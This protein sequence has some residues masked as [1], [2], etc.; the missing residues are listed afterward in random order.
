MEFFTDNNGSLY[1]QWEQAQGHGKR[2]WVQRRP[3]H[4]ATKNWA[5]VPD[6]RYLNVTRLNDLGNPGGNAAD[7]P[8]FSTLSDREILMAFVSA[9]SAITG[10]PFPTN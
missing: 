10:C 3:I 8:I 5:S 7:F 2:A 4:D 1:V 9:V 6:G